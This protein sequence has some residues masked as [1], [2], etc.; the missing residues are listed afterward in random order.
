MADT[1]QPLHAHPDDATIL[2]RWEQLGRPPIPIAFN[3]RGLVWKTIA[4]L[5]IYRSIPQDPAERQ[6][7]SAWVLAARPDSGS[8]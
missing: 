6:R 1:E 4:D 7:A 5:A 8:G 2:A 3:D